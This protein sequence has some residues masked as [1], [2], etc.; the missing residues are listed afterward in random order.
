MC[1]CEQEA[2]TYNGNHVLMYE[3]M[4]MNRAELLECF[5][6]RVFVGQSKAQ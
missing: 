3:R 4:P 1:L 6:A 2:L 5:D